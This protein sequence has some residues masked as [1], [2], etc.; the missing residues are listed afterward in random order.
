MSEVK[1]KLVAGLRSGSK[2]ADTWSRAGSGKGQLRAGD[3][4]HLLPNPAKG[5]APSDSALWM[6]E[7]PPKVSSVPCSRSWQRGPLAKLFVGSEERRKQNPH[8]H[9]DS[10]QPSLSLSKLRCHLHVIEATILKCIV[11]WFLVYS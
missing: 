7:V 4:H 9:L 3:K 2:S 5:R 6:G 10:L 1:S 8:Q 11:Q